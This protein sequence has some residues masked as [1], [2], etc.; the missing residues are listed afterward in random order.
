M[1]VA[2]RIAHVGSWSYDPHDGTYEWSDEMLRICG[3][4]PG[5]KA[6][7]GRECIAQDIDKFFSSGIRDLISSGGH[8]ELETRLVLPDGSTR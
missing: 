7:F 1:A 8:Q 2:Q 4:D 3:Y 6:T 5:Q